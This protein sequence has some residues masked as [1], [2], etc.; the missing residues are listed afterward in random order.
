MRVLF[1]LVAAAAFAAVPFRATAQEYAPS[2][3]TPAQVLDRAERARGAATVGAY[4]E[5]TR[6]INGER[7]IVSDALVDGDDYIET[8]SD[9]PIVRSSGTFHGIDWERNPNGVVVRMTDFAAAADPFRAALEAP[10]TPSSGAKVLGITSG[11]APQIVLEVRPREALLQRRYY[12]AQTFLL[13]RVETQSY[14]GHTQVREYG[15]YQAFK[16]RLVPRTWHYHDGS[17]AN[18]STT[19]V[20]SLESVQKVDPAKLAIPASSPPFTFS[21]DAPVEI[22]ATFTE[23]GI[24][25]RLTVNGRGLDFILDS[26][27]T[28]VTIDRETAQSLGL[29]LYGRNVET[30]GG[31][32]ELSSARLPDFSV[33]DLH[34]RAIAVDV[35][36]FTEGVADMKVV[37]LLGGDFFSS[38]VVTVD[39][40]NRKLTIGP[41]LPAA[42]DGFS[43]LP[44][45]IDDLVPMM[46]A[47]FN[48]KDGHFIADLGAAKTVLYPHYFTQFRAPDEPPDDGGLSFVGGETQTRTYRLSNLDLGDFAVQDVYVAVPLNR[49]VED[50]DYD[51][52]LGRDVLRY[53]TV[54]FDY[55][56]KTMYVKP[57]DA[58]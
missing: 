33:G 23:D 28:A 40:R 19:V 24:V 31:D 27:A 41:H 48:G 35:L 26:G 22:P 52:L 46:P 20:A 25:V 43:K 49:K 9:G 2:A 38:G 36:P 15:D 37:G 10:A 51:G 30:I 8:S 11:E 14:D 39:F 42:M 5:I 7:T 21:G 17:K 12:D 3:L 16:G 1:T 32:F 4:H 55:P 58:K 54:I 57:Y 13:Q 53:F 18:D 29:S 34:A 47:A 50:T 56:N 44:I 45:S 6:T